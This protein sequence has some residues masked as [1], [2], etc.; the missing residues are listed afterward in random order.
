MPG[1]G[2]FTSLDPYFGDTGEP[3]SL[4]KYA[5]V[6]GDPVNA[7]D[8]IG[9]FSLAGVQLN[10]SLT[11]TTLIRIT[12]PILR[13][14]ATAAYYSLSVRALAALGTATSALMW[15]E[16]LYYSISIT[17]EL[18]FA[19]VRLL[20]NNIPANAPMIREGPVG[21]PL[22]P[23]EVDHFT[24]VRIAEEQVNA[25]IRGNF[26]SVDHKQ[27]LR[28]GRVALTQFKTL[29]PNAVGGDRSFIGRI[30]DAAIDLNRARN[31]GVTGRDYRGNPVTIPG[32]PRN[33]AI[34]E[35]GMPRNSSPQSWTY[36]RQELHRINEQYNV[37][38]RPFMM[39]NWIRRR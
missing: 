30:E 11:Y 37:R 10:V 39:G 1:P 32:D 4:H 13:A 29:D 12:I 38:V 19:G 17:L 3:Q 36:I 20:A 15:L 33:L 22:L 7:W 16:I 34:I 9:L 2:M 23:G 25:N 8:P 26:P 31:N 24:R 5:Y 21:G 14:R 35:V 6:H 27:E 28:H 18:A